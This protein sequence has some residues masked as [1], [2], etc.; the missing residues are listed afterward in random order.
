M[1]VKTISVSQMAIVLGR[2]L[3]AIHE[4]IARDTFLFAQYWKTEGK[5]S[6]SFSIDKEGFKFYLSNTL[7]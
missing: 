5:K 1:L 2:T 7:G 3:T 4:C 6:R